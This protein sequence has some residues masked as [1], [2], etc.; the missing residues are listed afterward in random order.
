MYR[1]PLRGQLQW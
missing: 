1:K